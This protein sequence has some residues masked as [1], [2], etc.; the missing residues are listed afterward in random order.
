MPV[1]N[2]VNDLKDVTSSIMGKTSAVMPRGLAGDTV[3]EIDQ[4]KL[5]TA[6]EV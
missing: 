2:G 1:R 5:S 6:H 4:F 3:L